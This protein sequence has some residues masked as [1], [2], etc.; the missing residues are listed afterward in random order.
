MLLQIEALKAIG[1]DE[2]V[3]AINYEPEVKR[4]QV[5]ETSFCKAISVFFFIEDL[6]SSM[7]KNHSATA[8]DVEILKG[9]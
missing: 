3:L 1:V 4:L 8:S 7:L 2:V 6:N 5:F 9:R